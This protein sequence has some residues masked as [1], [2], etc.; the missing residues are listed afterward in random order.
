MFFML[1]SMAAHASSL[2]LMWFRCVPV[3]GSTDPG[4][5]VA[6][7]RLKHIKSLMCEQGV[8]GDPKK[9]LVLSRWCQILDKSGIYEVKL[10]PPSRP[11]KCGTL[12]YAIGRSDSPELVPVQVLEDWCD[13]VWV[14]GTDVDVEYWVHFDDVHFTS[15]PLNPKVI[16]KSELWKYIGKQAA[17][18]WANKRRKRGPN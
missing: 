18:E 13:R 12:I 15:I 6:F 10:E 9:H 17:A 11:L 5:E 1:F 2:T 7:E 4:Y 8:K 3:L 14:K 16:H